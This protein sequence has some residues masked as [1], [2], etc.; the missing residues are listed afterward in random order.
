MEKS[1]RE[2]WCRPLIPA[3]GRQRQAEAGRFLRLRPAWTTEFQ[4]N[5][6]YIE[7]PCPVAKNQEKKKD[8]EVRSNLNT[9][10]VKH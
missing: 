10:R 7:N 4:D 9:I 6:C 3:L 1:A 5:Q 2:W 8:G